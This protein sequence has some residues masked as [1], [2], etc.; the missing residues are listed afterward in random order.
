MCDYRKKGTPDG[1]YFGS[2]TSRHPPS[3]FCP[4]LPSPPN[5]P[6]GNLLFKFKR[7]AEIPHYDPVCIW[8]HV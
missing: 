5:Y 3:L 7:Y 6:N 1:L 8:G 4:L 2:A